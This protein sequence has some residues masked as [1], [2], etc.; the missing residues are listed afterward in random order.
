MPHPEKT[1]SISSPCQANT[2]D[3]LSKMETSHG[4]GEPELVLGWIP[5]KL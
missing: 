5:S 1:S 3:G 4:E 2:P